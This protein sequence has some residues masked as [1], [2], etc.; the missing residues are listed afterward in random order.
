MD[1]EKVFRQYD[2]LKVYALSA[3]SLRKETEEE[4]THLIWEH[5]RMGR[6]FLERPEEANYDQFVHFLEQENQKAVDKVRVWK[7]RVEAHGRPMLTKA[8]RTAKKNP[9]R[10][11]SVQLLPSDVMIAASA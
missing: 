7:G 10:A 8:Q 5:L 1:F 11:A 9:K 2:V 4:R 6:Q 3:R